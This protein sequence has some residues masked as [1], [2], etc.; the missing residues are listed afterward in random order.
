MKK[1][2][3]AVVNLA[4]TLLIALII[5]VGFP[6]VIVFFAPFVAGAIIALIARPLVRFLEEKVKIK[7]K[8]GSAFV[9]V[10]VIAL[11]VFVIYLVLVQLVEQ[12]MGLAADLP[13][14]WKSIEADLKRVG[15]KLSVFLAL[16]PGNMKVNI[17]DTAAEAVNYMGDLI[18]KFSSPTI[19]AAGNFAKRLPSIFI[20]VI[21]ALLSAYFFVA[22]RTQVSEWLRAHTPASIQIRYRMINNSLIKSVGGYFKAQLKI[23]VWMYL[24]LVIGL[25]LLKVDYF[26]LIALGIAFLDFFPFFGTGTV[27]VPWA[28]I[29][30]LTADYST[31]IWLLVIWGGGQL[32]RQLI[33]PKIMGDSM[34]VPPL[35]TLFLLY[36][37]Y[38]VGGVLGMIVAVPIGLV[39]YSL[40]QD[41]AFDTTKKSILILVAG[42]NKFRRLDGGDLVVVDEMTE[43]NEKV[44]D[45]LEK[46][47]RNNEQER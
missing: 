29:K 33:Q 40:Y 5:I 34:G 35:P 10:S 28:I 42:I 31:A 15:E 12:A 23:E 45:E 25:G 11:V 2:C 36:I 43:R 26:A 17:N 1:Y 20:G 37:G 19:E 14:M 46:L 39:L 3:K 18:E 13:D 24:L 32:L 6:K 4:V 47:H 30:I 16:L 41:G 9:I 22:D 8:I 27:M 21:M 7:R 38:K 44:A